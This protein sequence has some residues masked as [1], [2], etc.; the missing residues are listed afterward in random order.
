MRHQNGQAPKDSCV[1]AVIAIRGTLSAEDLITDF[2]CEPADMDDWMSTAATPHSGQGQG[3]HDP[4]GLVGSSQGTG[5]FGRPSSAQKRTAGAPLG[6]TLCCQI[7]AYL[8]HVI[9]HL[10][11]QLQAWQNCAVWVSVDAS[12]TCKA[13]CYCLE[14]RACCSEVMT[15][16]VLAN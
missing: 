8:W 6:H 7:C 4:K 13:I 3:S 12:Y 9:E 16:V 1:C 11:A 15:N 2:M 5:F 10:L 14:S